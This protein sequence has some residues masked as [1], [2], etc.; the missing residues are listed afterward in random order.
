MDPAPTGSGAVQ[1]PSARI[2]PTPRPHCCSPNR[3]CSPSRTSSTARQSARPLRLPELARRARY[4]VV[5]LD[6]RHPARPRPADRARRILALPIALDEREFRNRPGGLATPQHPADR[7]PRGQHHALAARHPGRRA[8][9]D[10]RGDR[11]AGLAGGWLQRAEL[12]ARRR[13]CS[14]RDRGR[15]SQRPH[16]EFGDAVS[17]DPQATAQTLAFLAQAEA[18]STDT[19]VRAPHPDWDDDQVQA[20]VDRILMETGATVPD[21]AAAVALRRASAAA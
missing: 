17:E 10:R 18:A 3:Q 2:S 11:A 4:D 7:V 21:P 19:K 20:R 12:R 8:S 6:A 1:Q 16:I 15:R 13:D 9:A 14:D 5:K